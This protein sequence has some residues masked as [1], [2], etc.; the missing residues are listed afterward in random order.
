MPAFPIPSNLVRDGVRLRQWAERD[1]EGM[2]RWG[3]DRAI[4]RFTGVPA[5]NTREHVLA[6][7]A[8]REERRLAGSAVSFMIVDAAND[9][10][11]GNCDLRLL[12]ES[13]RGLSEL[14]YLLVES[15]RGRGAAT[16]AVDLIVG[17]GFEVM[18]IER[19]QALV[20]PD[21]PA[22]GRVLERN[23]FEL[24]GL[25]RRYRPGASGRE[26]RL[27]YARVSG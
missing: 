13:D 17:Y 2:T 14:G 25:L 3:A 22:S 6:N 8:A 20:H 23:G 24:E 11:L 12:S 4:T 26:D 10:V 5:V 15:A 7:A 16:T 9:A 18:G 21:N 1:L 27:L 19:V